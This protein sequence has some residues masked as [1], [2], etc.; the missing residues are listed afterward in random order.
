MRVLRLADPRPVTGELED[1]VLAREIELIDIAS[2]ETRGAADD[3][4]ARQAGLRGRLQARRADH[5]GAGH[6]G[7]TGRRGPHDDRRQGATAAD[8][9]VRRNFNP[10]APDVTWCGDITYL[11]TGEGWLYLATVIDLFAGG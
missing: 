10:P 1:R 6:R 5:A 11:H 8:D 4:L 7:R 9:D 2:G 3:R